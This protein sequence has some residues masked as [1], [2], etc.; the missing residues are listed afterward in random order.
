MRQFQ[1]SEFDR[2]SAPKVRPPANRARPNDRPTMNLAV[3]RVNAARHR[4]LTASELVDT[5]V[6]RTNV[7]P[8][9]PRGQPAP[10]SPRTPA[11]VGAGQMQH[12]SYERALEPQLCLEE[13]PPANG[14]RH[15][16]LPTTSKSRAAHP[17]RQSCLMQRFLRITERLV[18]LTSN[19]ALSRCGTIVWFERRAS[20][21]IGLNA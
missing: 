2:A 11:R 6:T 20:S 19:A 1:T 15:D 17:T 14:A 21:A 5:P 16:K 3:A 7:R 13:Q 18:H 12:H 10:T 9:T 8:P 4:K